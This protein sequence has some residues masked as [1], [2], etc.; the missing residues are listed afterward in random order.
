MSPTYFR[1]VKWK[2]LRD[3]FVLVATVVV[4]AAQ[5]VIA[6]N[7]ISLFIVDEEKGN[8]EGKSFSPTEEHLPAYAEWTFHALAIQLFTPAYQLPLDR[9]VEMPTPPPDHC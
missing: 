1:A 3:L 9:A 7:E 5:S 6:E 2:A 4:P 8:S